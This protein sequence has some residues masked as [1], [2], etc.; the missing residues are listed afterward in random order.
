M[1]VRLTLDRRVLR[2]QVIDDGVGFAPDEVR[3]GFG[4]RSMRER[5]EALGGELVIRSEEGK[6]TTVEALV[7]T[8]P[9]SRRGP[10]TRGA[11]GYVGQAMSD[12][13]Q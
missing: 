1:T 13:A 6:G 9:F 7:P 4:L 5:V 2:L 12:Q 3:R 8:S 10:R 11:N